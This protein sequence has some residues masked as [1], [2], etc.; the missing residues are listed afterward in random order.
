MPGCVCRK[1]NEMNE[2]ITYKM[3]VKFDTSVYMGKDFQY[4]CMYSYAKVLEVNYKQCWDVIK[5][6]KG[7]G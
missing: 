5:L 7:M 1:V 2:K 3:G 4:Y 6:T